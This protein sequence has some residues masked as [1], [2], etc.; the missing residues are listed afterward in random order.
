MNTK[1]CL[2]CN[3]ITQKKIS[4]IVN[5][6]DDHTTLSRMTTS[7]PKWFK[8]AGIYSP[9]P[10][11]FTC[12]NLDISKHNLE[13]K[14][15]KDADIV[16]SFD[17][18]HLNLSHKPKWLYYWCSKKRNLDDNNYGSPID[19]YGDFSNDGLIKLSDTDTIQL[20]VHD[21]TPYKVDGVHYPPH[22]HFTVLKKNNL[23]STK[24][25]AI[26]TYPQ[27]STEQFVDIYQCNPRKY[28]I[29]NAMGKLY[30]GKK[31]PT[32][33]NTKRIPYST[34]H[35][36]IKK[37]I[38]KYILRFKRN[39]K[40]KHHVVANEVSKHVPIVV[41]C[42]NPKCNASHMLADKLLEL[43]FVNVLYYNDGYEGFV[44]RN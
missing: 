14:I 13:E 17:V 7:I 23:W 40:L 26:D 44:K 41:Y 24:P 19:A 5:G 20:H 25:W 30:N 38:I 36:K 34:E 43:G 42:A 16:I 37:K 10:K 4:C 1:T 33:K 12:G 31:T 11:I 2:N 15:C 29:L 3:I 27:L 28:I 18:S 6:R 8:K 22:I 39:I 32:I 21:P 9:L 35:S